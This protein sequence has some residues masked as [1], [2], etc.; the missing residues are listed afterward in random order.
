MYLRHFSILILA[1]AGLLPLMAWSQA[2]V[3]SLVDNP[4]EGRVARLERLM[5]S[6]SLV[7]MLSRLERLQQEVQR[8]RGDIEVLNHRTEQIR[9]QQRDLYRDL[10]GRLSQLEAGGEGAPAFAGPAGGSTSEP[11]SSLEI[12]EAAV[13]APPSQDEREA[14]NQAFELLK[15][16]Q[17]EAAH[18]AFSDLL[19]EFPEGSYAD[20]AQY[21]MGESSY[22]TRDFD[23]ALEAF[24]AV[25][26]NHPQSPKVPDA[27]LKVGYIHY[28]QGRWKEARTALE[29][30]H[31]KFP[32]TTAARLAEQRLQRMSDEGH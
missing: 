22:V 4:L 8:L 12:P 28:E 18:R 9:K 30:V 2:P 20:N 32:G 5:A 23:Q 31:E 26:K 14:Y 24:E 17:Y 3:T 7:E 1:A 19:T 15:N 11:G 13:S 16:G 29:A 25:A 10:D 27:L 6:Q 21:W